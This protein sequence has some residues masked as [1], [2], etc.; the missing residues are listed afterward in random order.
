[1][2]AQKSS[3]AKKSQTPR[4]KTFALALG[5]GGARGLAHIVVIEALDELGLRP[6]AIA[7]TSI[8]AAIG[9]AYAAGMSGKTM[10]RYVTTL[11]HN[12]PDV[13]ARLMRTRG[14]ALSQMFT[15]AFGNPMVLDS[16]KFSAAFLPPELP[17][18]FADLGIPLRI[19][20]ADL[21]SRDEVVFTEGLLRPAISASMAVPGLLRPVEIDGRIL[22]DGGAVNPL[23]FDQLRD[24]ADIIVAVDA[25]VGPVAPRGVPD[26]WETL[27]STLQVMGH[28]IVTAKLKDHAPDLVLRPNVGVFRMLDFFQASSILRAAEPIKAEI[29]DKLGALLSVQLNEPHSLTSHT[30]PPP[31]SG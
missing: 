2:S 9:A 17:E 20:A 22:V 19:I 24:V 1:M 10:R 8:G 31:E 14:A 5:G 6:I 21:Y 27:F 28:T 4:A 16:E 13:W 15:T 25:S 29:R 12:R 30:R 18:R 7:G 23:P 26:P 3:A 11:A